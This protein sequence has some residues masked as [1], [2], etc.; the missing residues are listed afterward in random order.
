[1]VFVLRL[2]TLHDLAYQQNIPGV[3]LQEY[4]NANSLQLR[5]SGKRNTVPV[6]RCVLLESYQA[7]TSNQLF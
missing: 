2:N 5:S 4:L 3:D 6:V 1:M 7:V